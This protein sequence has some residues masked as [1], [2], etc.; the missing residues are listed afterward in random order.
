VQIVFPSGLKE[1][2]PEMF[3]CISQGGALGVER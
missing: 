1:S 3:E 2:T